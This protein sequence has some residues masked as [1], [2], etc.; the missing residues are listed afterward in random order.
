MKVQG[1]Y[2]FSNS[3]KTCPAE[4]E[5]MRQAAR[6]NEEATLEAV[7]SVKVGSVWSEVVTAYAVALAKKGGRM[8]YLNTYLGGLP[9]DKVIIGEPFFI[10]EITKSYSF[11]SYIL[12]IYCSLY[13]GFV[14]L[15]IKFFNN[16]ILKI[17][18]FPALIVLAEFTCANFLYGFPWFSFALINSNNFFGLTAI[19]CII[20]FFLIG[21]GH[22]TKLILNSKF[23][24]V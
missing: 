24:N 14:F 1:T 5:I 17:L 15:I 13:F 3:S 11:F 12:I 22:L 19:G 23:Q 4:I 20:P 2:Y 16:I 8:R 21:S 18:M 6:I 9:K 10:D 7:S